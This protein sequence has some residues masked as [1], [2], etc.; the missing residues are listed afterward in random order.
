MNIPS[1]FD[2]DWRA[3]EIVPIPKKGDIKSPDN[4]RGFSLLDVVGKFF[5]RI[6]QDRLQS[7]AEEVLPDSRCGFRKG[8]GCVDMIHIARQLIETSAGHDSESY[9]LFVDLQKADDSI[10]RTGLWLV[11]ERLGVSP[12]MLSLIRSLHDS[13]EVRV[14]FSGEFTDG[15]NVTDGL[16]QGCTLVPT[17]FNLHVSAVEAHW[18][19]QSSTP[20]VAFHY[21]VRRK[22]VGDRPA[23]SCLAAAFMSGSRF[24]DVA[25]LYTTLLSSLE[26]MT[27][28]FISCASQCGRTVSIRKIKAKAINSP[29]PP[30]YLALALCFPICQ[31]K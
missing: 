29:N 27:R 15:I 14:R 5:A 9:F 24:A 7:I 20:H 11:V 31:W 4:W 10:P 18:R 16:R 8:R 22:V 26:P 3:A 25:S 30:Q 12:V 6:I 19:N 23:K 2:S 17:L 1:S 28:E 13:T 21:C